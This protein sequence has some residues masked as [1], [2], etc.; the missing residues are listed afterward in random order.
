[1]FAVCVK[2]E[3]PLRL[4][5]P[6]P[7]SGGLIV[8]SNLRSTHRRFE[9]NTSAGLDYSEG[10]YDREIDENTGML[11]TQSIQT[12]PASWKACSGRRVMPSLTG[13][14]KNASVSRPPQTTTVAAN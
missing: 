8:Q 1:M 7:S 13:H 2:S 11:E 12:F 5:L 4:N 6:S 10:K 3:Q 14:T 9:Q